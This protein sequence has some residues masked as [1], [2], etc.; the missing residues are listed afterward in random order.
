MPEE[1]HES[2]RV[3]V[4]RAKRLLEATLRFKLPYNAY[5]HKE[6]VSLDML[7]GH[8]ES[9]DLNG[10][11]LDED[12]RELTRIYIES[13]NLD[14]AGSQSVEFKRFLAQA[15]SATKHRLG[16]ETPGI[17]PKYEFMW[18][19]T[20]PWKGDGFRQVATWQEV[21][22]AVMWDRDRSLEVLVAGKR[23]PRAVPEGHVVD[24]ELVRTVAGRI[25]VWVISDRH[26]E[27]TM[28][29]KLRGWVQERLERE[30]QG[31]VA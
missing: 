3:G 17:D 7:T 27:M 24:K 2:G 12:G 29:G 21:R 26:E 22:D 25:W 4:T 15:Y 16:A 31:E 6:R 14:G 20:C 8:V 5:Q 18:A 19:T 28:G 11:V 30:R 9:Y 13:K 10:D 23:M 1:Q